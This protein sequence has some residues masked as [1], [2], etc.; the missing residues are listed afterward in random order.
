ML[1]FFLLRMPADFHNNSN[2]S[3][4]GPKS[5]AEINTSE[6]ESDIKLFACVNNDLMKSDKYD[7]EKPSNNV[8]TNEVCINQ[9]FCL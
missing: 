2:N 5:N 9:I 1:F 4:D 3:T 6:A 7:S 8:E